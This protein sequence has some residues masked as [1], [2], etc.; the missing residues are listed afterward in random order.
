MNPPPHRRN[1]LYLSLVEA[2][3]GV[4][5]SVIS[6]GTV[7][8]VYLLGAGASNRVIALLPAL[9]ALGAG[10]TQVFS[11]WLVRRSSHIKGWVL[12]LHVLAPTPLALVGFWLLLGRGGGV[13]AVLV[14]WGAFYAFL[15]ILFPIWLDYMARILDPARRGRAFG[16]IFFVQTTAGVGGAALASGV[17]ERSTSDGAYALLFFA[18]A[19]AMAGGSLLFMGTRGE[20]PP[21]GPT[22]ASSSSEHFKEFFGLWREA[23]W[24]RSYMVARWLTRGTYPLVVTFYAAR[25]VAELGATPSQAALLGVAALGCQAVAGIAAGHLGDHFGHRTAVVLGQAG[26]LVA[27]V[28]VLLPIPLSGYF[29]VAA[30][31]GVYLATEYASQGNWIMELAGP[32]RRRGALALV[33]VLLTPT[34]VAVPLLGGWLMDKVGFRPVA[35]GVAAI[36]LIAMAVEMRLVPN[37]KPGGAREPRK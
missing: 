16:A 29:V 22:T 12:A 34:A 8:P 33:G 32:S 10:I 35:A 2:F 26:L 1:T 14:G 18:A 25:A 15:G 17:L 5:L 20:I 24:M 3:W 21:P 9:G 28:L 31:T 37:P 7:L 6:V 23:P 4:G 13:A 30:L 19:A 11:G 36:L 27:S